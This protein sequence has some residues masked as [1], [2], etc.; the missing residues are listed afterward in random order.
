MLLVAF[1]R[2]PIP[3]FRSRC[4]VSSTPSLCSEYD[5][6]LGRWDGGLLTKSW[7][8]ELQIDLSET[9]TNRRLGSDGP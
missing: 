2:T 3:C 9:V 1:L 6:L 7:P 4:F 5:L 8:A